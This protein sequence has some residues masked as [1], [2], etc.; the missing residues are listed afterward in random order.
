MGLIIR[1]QLGNQLGPAGILQ[2]F[3]QIVFRQRLPHH[4]CQLYL[5]DTAL[6]Q[7]GQHPAELV[8]VGDEVLTVCGAA[9]LSHAFGVPGLPG[10]GIF[11]DHVGAAFQV[12]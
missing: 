10:D 9:E 3:D 11:I 7:V 12:V 6:D 8:A 5:A 2:L 4:L 1:C